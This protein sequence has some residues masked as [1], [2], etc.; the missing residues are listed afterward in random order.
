MRQQYDCFQEIKSH[1][2]AS[3]C[4]V[5]LL[6]EEKGK[7]GTTFNYCPLYGASMDKRWDTYW[8]N[9]Y[10]F[11]L[12]AIFPFPLSWRKS[13]SGNYLLK[14]HSNQ[15]LNTWSARARDLNFAVTVTSSARACSGI[16]ST[17]KG[18]G[19]LGLPGRQPRQ[20][21]YGEPRALCVLG[22]V[23]SNTVLP[24]KAFRAQWC[25][26]QNPSS[27]HLS[28]LWGIFCKLCVH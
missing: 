15:S 4:T 10:Y 27:Q 28:W 11:S 13:P 21:R 17:E 9:H 7:E 26:L 2:L 12:K 5:T 6:E 20:L 16:C 18:P 22:S 3:Y 1:V 24:S 19:H 14:K 23:P 8:Q 25:F